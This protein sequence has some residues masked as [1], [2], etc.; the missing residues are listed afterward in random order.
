MAKRAPQS[1][2]HPGPR[3]PSRTRGIE[4]FNA[5][6]D[7]AERLLRDESPT[8]VGLY[9]IAREAGVP[10]AS[11]YHFFPT[12]EAAFLALA[13]RYFD[14]FL[15]IRE[16]AVD[17]RSLTGWQALLRHDQRRGMEFYNAHPPAMKILYGGYGT[18][19]IRQADFQTTDRLAEG[20]YERMN[21]AFHMPAIR[22]SG[23]IA[24]IMLAI[25][26]A[27]W[28]LSFLREG[29]ITEAYFEQA[30]EATIAYA[31]L[32][33]P[34][35]VELRDALKAAAAAGTDIV[36]PTTSIAEN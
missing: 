28:A 24:R 18:L 26:D 10:P 11:V 3:W 15:A 12:K 33:L 36:V 30:F 35:R 27:I 22:E 20:L 31:R 25:M 7:A 8:D 29:R 34:E 1:P 4:R 9:Q 5:L 23:N 2:G 13:Q 6:L 16:E 32:F 21:G 14:Y 19:E 17:A